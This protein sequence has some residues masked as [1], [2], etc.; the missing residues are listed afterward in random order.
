MVFVSKELNKISKYFSFLLRH[1]PQAIGLQLDENGWASIEELIEKTTDFKLDRNMIEVVVETNDKQRFSISKDGLFIRANQGH[2]IEI[3]LDLIA[4]E[5]PSVL[6]H[7]TAE[8]FMVNIL[9]KG[10]SKMERH[11]VHLTESSAVAQSVGSRYGKPI[12]LSIAA[13]EM[14]EDGF[15]FYKSANNVWLVDS[16]PV[17]YIKIM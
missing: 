10:L 5:P 3:D 14:Y 15:K 11:H 9:D 4:Q 12:I 17:K 16:V 1:E 2:S 8:R 13:K 6:M 7:G